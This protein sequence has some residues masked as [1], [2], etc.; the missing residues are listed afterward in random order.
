MGGYVISTDLYRSFIVFR[1]SKSSFWYDNFGMLI[2]NTSVINFYFYIYIDCFIDGGGFI[3][4]R[5][6]IIII[7]RLRARVLV[8]ISVNEVFFNVYSINKL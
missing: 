2:F 4:V 7:F 3:Y 1:S 5:V 6:Y 8:F